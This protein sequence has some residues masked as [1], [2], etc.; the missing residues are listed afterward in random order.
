MNRRDL[1]KTLAAVS[2]VT[3]G[4]QTA[5]EKK[6]PTEPLDLERK[7][8][9][10]LAGKRPY[11]PLA[12]PYFSPDYKLPFLHIGTERQ[13][14]VDNFILEH[15]D[16]VERVIV[17]PEKH[18]KLLLEYGG[19]PWE[20]TAFNPL[21]T[22][23]LYDP[24]D[25]KF[26]MWYTQSLSGDP[27][28]TG[29]VLC[30]AQS[31]NALDWERPMSEK[32]IPY[33]GHKATNIVHTDD[34]SGTGLALNHD[35]SDPE[36]KFLLLYAPAIEAR[37]E[38]SRFFSR[39]AASADGLRWKVI[40]RDVPQRHQHE[41]KIFF[42]EAIQEWVAYSQHSH[43]WHYGP[44]IRQMGRQTSKDFIHWS[45]K[46]VVLSTDWDPTLGP[47]RE[48]H[49]GSVRKVGGLYLAIVAEAHTEPIW[50]SRTETLRG[51]YAG[52]VWRDQFR[53]SLALYVSRDG[54]RFTRAHGPEA[55]V[56]NGP[57]GSPDHGY[58]CQTPA[59]A[60]Y[61]QGKV[62]V[63][64]IAV[65]IKQWTLPRKDW[66]LVPDAARLRYEQEIAAANKLGTGRNSTRFRRGVGALVLREDGWAMLKP[67]RE[68][69][70]VVTKQF[71]FEGDRLRINAD[72]NFGDI[73]VEFLDPM[74]RPYEGF[75]AED[76]DPVHNENRDAIWHTV[77]W[78][79][80]SDVRALW[81][82]PV[83]AAFHL[84]ESLLYGFEFKSGA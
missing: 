9:D 19:L 33:K 37:K 53:V 51:M 14:F 73:R 16:E 39:V 80:R 60:L 7:I 36:R 75:S 15:L 24:D 70:R 48:F 78:K 59:G 5:P 29:Q 66:Q 31:D 71:V 43:H 55:W 32:C 50:N 20:E 17:K 82:K 52:T 69:G 54:R 10:T 2:A 28:G 22:A 34:V 68:R 58:A 74:F 42:D 46:E 21:I 84:N 81:N 56:D 83:L 49:D 3:G 76:C 23:T 25:R 65:P 4:A 30:Y 62:I 1:F 63:P 8:G 79:G 26:K 41:S 38:G 18:S 72:C 27:Y 40:S 6:S 57:P 35:R 13:L 61:H 67:R 64:Y 47:D 44:R 12:Y 77:T 11:E 45:P